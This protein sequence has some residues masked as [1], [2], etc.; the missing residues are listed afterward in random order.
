M[1]TGSWRN[2]FESW[3]ESCGQFKQSS[4]RGR[5]LTAT[6]SMW[7]KTNVKWNLMIWWVMWHFYE[8]VSERQRSD[9]TQTCQQLSNHCWIIILFDSTW[10]SSSC[11]GAWWAAGWCWWTSWRSSSGSAPGSPST[12]CGSSCRCWSMSSP[13]AGRSP[14][15]SQS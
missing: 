2:R 1:R 11:C 15:I 13:R 9:K 10:T 7:I 8:R 6:T 14:H 3:Q 4:T 5:N 12:A